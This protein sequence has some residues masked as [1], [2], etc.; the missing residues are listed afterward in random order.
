MP[1]R[2][3]ARGIEAGAQVMR[4][5]R[6]ET[7][8]VH[9]VLARPH[10]LDRTA[11][12]LRQHHRV[13]DEV[14]VAIA[15]ATEAAAHQQIVQLHLVARNAE[16]LGRRF[17]APWSGSACR[18][19]FRRHRQPARPRRPRSAAPSARDRHSRND[20][21]LRPCWPHS[22]TAPRALPCA[23]QSRAGLRQV[24]RV[25]RE[26]VVPLV[27]VEAPGHAGPGPGHASS[28]SAWRAENAAHA[29][30]GDYA[31][32]MRQPDRPR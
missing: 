4:R 7:A 32:A 20:I 30:L 5:Q 13:H 29:R 9:V 17:R 26:G 25:G 22:G 19:R 14:D 31:D 18:P 16:E 12:F 21:R 10:H 8:V 2:E 3:L 11:D 1:C 23:L 27:A 24:L 6:P 28:I 15:A